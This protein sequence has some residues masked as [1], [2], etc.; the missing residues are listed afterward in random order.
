MKKIPSLILLFTLALAS[1]ATPT[2]PAPVPV[3]P[4]FAPPTP[5]PSTPTPVGC[6]SIDDH[7]SDQVYPPYVSYTDV[8]IPDFSKPAYLVSTTDPAFGAEIIRITDAA[9]FG[10]NNVRHGYSKD[11]AWNC[12]QTLI[13]INGNRILDGGTYQFLRFLDMPN[14]PKWSHLDPNKL[15]GISGNKFVSMNAATGVSTT[16]HTFTGYSE[17]F[18]GP[19]EGNISTDDA[20]VAFI[21]SEVSGGDIIVYDILHDV[22]VAVKSVASL[23]YDGTIDWVSVSQSGN[24][25]VINGSGS[26]DN[27]VKSYD[28]N[29]NPIATLF[30][31]G[32]HADLCYDTY[33][34][35]TLVSVGDPGQMARLDNGQQTTIF[36]FDGLFWGHVSCR[37]YKRP[38][39]AYVSLHNGDV[40][41]I[42]LDGSQ[43]VERFAHHRSSESIYEA[44][45]QSAPNPNGTKIMY[46]SDWNGTAEIN[47]Y[48]AGQ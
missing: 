20:S 47:S 48:V 30:S 32:E 29:L 4:T 9:V 15:F 33:G 23:G 3:T 12:D 39:W 11:Q 25:V 43:T 18:M 8:G 7:S 16:L 46:A 42:K 17:I 27:S 41:A 40:M 1:C 19:W 31:Q 44:E 34:N 13:K 6:G 2:P 26:S 10:E 14:E 36:D 24:F 22:V 38:G 21:T 37:N 28:R 5:A 35:E 45:A